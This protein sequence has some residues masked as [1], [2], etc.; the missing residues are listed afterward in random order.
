MT[1]LEK[2]LLRAHSLRIQGQRVLR[3]YLYFPD[4]GSSAVYTNFVFT[5]KAL[6]DYFLQHFLSKNSS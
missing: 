1:S 6:E 3:D 5:T 4:K 2:Q